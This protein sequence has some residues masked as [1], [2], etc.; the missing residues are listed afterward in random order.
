MQKKFSMACFHCSGKSKKEKLEYTKSQ[1][2]QAMDCNRSL[3]MSKKNF[4]L[5]VI[6]K[7]EGVL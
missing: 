6:N 1:I 7:C 5:L 2:E 3:K 4:F